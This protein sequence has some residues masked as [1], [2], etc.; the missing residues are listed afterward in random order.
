[1]KYIK[2]RDAGIITP[3]KIRKN[4]WEAV[5]QL[6]RQRGRGRILDVLE[7]EGSYALE[8]AAE[9]FS[10]VSVGQELA[11]TPDGAP[12]SDMLTVR[13][14]DGLIV[15]FLPAS[16]SLLPRFLLEKDRKIRCFVEYRDYTNDL[17]TVIVSLYVERY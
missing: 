4:R 14:L 1:M 15:G 13:T 3:E 6:G 5:K 10:R 8:N 16:I 2:K 17:L 12:N 7:L 9:V 11:V